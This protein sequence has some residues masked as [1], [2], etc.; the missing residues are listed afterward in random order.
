MWNLFSVFVLFSSL[1][2]CSQASLYGKDFLQCS[3]WGN[4]HGYNFDNQGFDIQGYCSYILATTNCMNYKAGA[5]SPFT[6]EIERSSDDKTILALAVNIE[7]YGQMY[8]LTRGRGLLVDGVMV[9][10]PYKSPEN[11]V[12]ISYQSG[13][14]VFST[15]FLQLHWDG[16]EHIDVYLCDDYKGKVC[17]LCGNADGNQG[18]DFNGYN[19]TNVASES[20]YFKYKDWTDQWQNK[21]GAKR[22]V[23]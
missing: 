15:K 17:G 22:F 3:V 18:N 21:N 11:D 1:Y 4:S 6:I 20:K 14:M 7:I 23:F 9:N 16:Y 13:S 10:K 12:L 8:T 2:S 5:I 19:Q